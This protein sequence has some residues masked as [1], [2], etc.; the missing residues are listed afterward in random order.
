M[1]ITITY[2]LLDRYLNPILDGPKPKSIFMILLPEHR[3]HS[4]SHYTMGLVMCFIYNQHFK[5]IMDIM[6]KMGQ[7]S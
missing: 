7:F 6:N 5:L 1:H 4:A 3:T 2:T